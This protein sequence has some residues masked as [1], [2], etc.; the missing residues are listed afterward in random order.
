[1][2][3]KINPAKYK[4]IASYAVDATAGLLVLSSKLSAGAILGAYSGYKNK[5]IG[6]G[7]SKG[8]A[9]GL[10][11][12]TANDF[13]SVAKNSFIN[14]NM[15]TIP[16]VAPS[17][18]PPKMR[19]AISRTIQV[20]TTEE[21]SN[22][23][24]NYFADKTN[25]TVKDVQAFIKNMNLLNESYEFELAEGVTPINVS[26]FTPSP[27]TVGVNPRIRNFDGYIDE[28]ANQNV[29]N[30]LIYARGLYDRLKARHAGVEVSFHE[31]AT[32][33][34]ERM[35][36]E[37]KTRLRKEITNEILDNYHNLLRV[38]KNIPLVD[39]DVN[40]DSIVR[41]LSVATIENIR[42]K[43]ERAFAEAERLKLEKIK[44]ED[45][46]ENDAKRFE[47]E[48]ERM[49]LQRQKEEEERERL[50]RTT[51]VSTQIDRD[52]KFSNASN[53]EPKIFDSP[54]T[55]FSIDINNGYGQTYTIKV[56]VK[57]VTFTIDPDEIIELI[58]KKIEIGDSLKR[59][60][61]F[62][63]RNISLSQYLLRTDEIRLDSMLTKVAYGRWGEFIKSRKGLSTCLVLSEEMVEFM[64][65][66]KD[67]D[68][69]ALGKSDW[70]NLANEVGILDVIIYNESTD[71]ISILERVAG[72]YTF[73]TYSLS[74][75]YAE[76]RNYGN[77]SKIVIMPK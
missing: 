32:N 50:S 69:Y 54:T 25:F 35:R 58:S 66:K 18:I 37:I 6:K 55:I 1:M 38:K 14:K 43:L 44:I 4:K 56:G 36:V 15:V 28:I 17:I 57:A 53:I 11:R 5:S 2:P 26:N 71:S 34:I 61:S 49:N 76:T 9:K 10:T 30:L 41:Q 7:F 23:V 29:D 51:S 63:R 47:L 48:K 70:I 21:I 62:I 20:R 68:L 65:K 59:F 3:K 77:D 27:N 40:L 42:H 33:E 8:F 22:Y 67:I 24:S 75:I 45:K 31:M 52:T 12:L 73:E 64:L 13:K 74:Q 46:R 39:I 60:R 72:S 19:V 16:L